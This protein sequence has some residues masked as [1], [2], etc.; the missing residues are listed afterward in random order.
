M[1]GKFYHVRP[2]IAYALLACCL[3]A[4]ASC[5]V[6]AGGFETHD[7]V[8]EAEATRVAIAAQDESARRA[9]E[10]QILAA[11]ADKAWMEAEAMRQAV[12]A[13]TLRNM[14][15]YAG[16]GIGVVVLAIGSAF[17]VVAWLNKRATA[18]YPNGAGQYPVIVKRSWNG[19][20]IVHDP[21]RA[22]GPTTIYT[23]PSLVDVVLRKGNQSPAAQF[24]ASGSEG[25]MLQLATQAQAIG[26]VAA[27]SRNAT[28]GGERAEQLAQTL[29]NRPAMP[30]GPIGLPPVRASSLEPSH[31]ERL[32]IE[33]ED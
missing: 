17:A 9:V 29:L 12:P 32:L 14:L 24:P 30:A 15:V 3:M 11:Q 26:L 1:D 20:T 23:T 22:L 7:P 16:T 27:A 4:L 13:A 8:R 31:V 2:C 6:K 18:V 19:V 33:A 10:R 25:S 5:T 21:N 28:R